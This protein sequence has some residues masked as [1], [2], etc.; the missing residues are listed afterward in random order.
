MKIKYISSLVAFWVTLI[1]TLLMVITFK[2]IN[3]TVL[4]GILLAIINFFVVFFFVRYWLQKEFYDKIRTIYKNIYNFKIDK[5]GLKKNINSSKIGI[6]EVSDEVDHW[7]ENLRMK[8]I[9]II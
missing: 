8:L 4:I 6:K 7:M 3:V 2:Y 1:M 9:Y 5:Q